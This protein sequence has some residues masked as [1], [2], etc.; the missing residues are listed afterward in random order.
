[1]IF[2]DGDHNSGRPSFFFDQVATF[3]ER[4]LLAEHLSLEK[5]LK[6][7]EKLKSL[8]REEDGLSIEE[9][10]KSDK[11]ENISKKKKRT[12]LISDSKI[13]EL[14]QTPR[15]ENIH[16]PQSLYKKDI[17]KEDKEDFR[18]KLISSLKEYYFI[19]FFF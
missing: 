19:F 17:T 12:T 9:L 5:K 4:T 15:G 11:E 3:F 1:M 8:Q 10:L 13:S 18:L 2:F 16:M 7:D 14:P 6:E